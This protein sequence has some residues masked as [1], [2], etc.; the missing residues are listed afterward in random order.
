MGYMGDGAVGAEVWLWRV[1]NFFLQKVT[2][3]VM[4]AAANQ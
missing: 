4:I 2:L 3:P 1:D